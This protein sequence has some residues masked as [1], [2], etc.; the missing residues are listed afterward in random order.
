[1][2]AKEMF[3][4][5]GYELIKRN[6]LTYRSDDGGYIQQIMFCEPGHR[7]ILREWETYENNEPQGQFTVYTNLLK[8]INK[9]I[10][11]LGWK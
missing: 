1:M 4:E 6:V 2:S 8:A 9:Q 7:I 3:E 11:E 5:L 10:E